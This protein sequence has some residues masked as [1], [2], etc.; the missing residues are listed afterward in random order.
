MINVKVQ[1]DSSLRGYRG[2]ITVTIEGTPYFQFSSSGQYVDFVRSL[3]ESAQ[4]IVETEQRIDKS[5]T[6]NV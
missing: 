4:G 6:T 5:D 1:V 3:A 2:Y